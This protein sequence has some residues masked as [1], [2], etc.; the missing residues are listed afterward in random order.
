M[1][2]LIKLI[3]LLKNFKHFRSIEP[4]T[5]SKGDGM[6]LMTYEEWEGQQEKKNENK[7]E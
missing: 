3:K 6:S 5:S 4:M 1:N 2:T 7:Y